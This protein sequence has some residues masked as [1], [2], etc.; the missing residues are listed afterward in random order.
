MR[1]GQRSRDGGL[2]TVL[3]VSQELCCKLDCDV[4]VMDEN[5]QKDCH[6]S[7]LF[8][9]ARSFSDGIL[10]YHHTDTVKPYRDRA[11]VCKVM[12]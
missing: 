12:K 3:F 5:W 10:V 4:F 9:H 1:A 2:A 8:R 6:F 11:I 7:A